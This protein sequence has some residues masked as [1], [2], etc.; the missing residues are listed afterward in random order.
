MTVGAGARY[1]WLLAA[2]CALALAPASVMVSAANASGAPLRV[3]LRV[4]ANSEGDVNRI[5][6]AVASAPGAVC[7]LRV[8]AGKVARG[9][10]R[11]RV[12]ASGHISWHWYS[13]APPSQRPWRFYSRCTSG[14]WYAWRSANVELGFPSRGGALDVS[15]APGGSC[16]TQG[17]CFAHDPFSIGQCGWYAQGRRPDLLGIVNGNAG[18]WLQE[19]KGHVPEGSTPVVGALAV[20]LPYVNHAGWEGH[21]GYVAAVSDGRVLIDDSNW[22]PTPTSNGLEVHEHWIAASAPSGYI[23][24]GPA[25]NGP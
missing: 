13:P 25:G 16:D 3:A 9:F 6:V 4:S 15:T 7:A 12:G 24:G 8:T 19:A 17:V 10:S 11:I 23:Y 1:R 20:W 5:D 2:G 14:Q 21:V 22:T 18:T